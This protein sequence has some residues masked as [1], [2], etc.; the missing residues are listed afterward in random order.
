MNNFTENN[1]WRAYG[2]ED[3]MVQIRFETMEK[4]HNIFIMTKGER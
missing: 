3:F 4:K 1:L 2:N